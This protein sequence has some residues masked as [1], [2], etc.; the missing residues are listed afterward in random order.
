MDTTQFTHKIIAVSMVRQA[1]W[2][3]DESQRDAAW[4]VVI[5][6]SNENIRCEKFLNWLYL[7]AEIDR[8][9]EQ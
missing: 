1:I 5:H 3:S 9:K 2:Q 8:G 7:S 6:Y 4:K